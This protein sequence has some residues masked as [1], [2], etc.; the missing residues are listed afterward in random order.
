MNWPDSVIWWHCYPLRFVD[1]ERE[2]I[3][4][5]EPRLWRLTNWLDYV[6]ELGANGLLLAPVFASRTHGY[7]TIDHYRIDPR[8][9][10]DADF[11]DLIWKAKE[12][13]VRV[14]LDG[15]FNHVS[16]HHEIVR[17][18]LADG[19]GSEA[20][21]WI[22]W[23]DGYPRGFEGNLDLVE[24]D[25]SHPPVQDYVVG[26]M[27]HWLDRGA[28]GWRLDAAYAAGPEAW[29]P[30][31]DRVRQAHPDAWI[32]AEVIHGDYVDFVDRSGVDSVT[33]YELWKAIWSSLNDGNLHELAWTLSRH[34]QFAS[35]FRPLN[36]VGNHDTTRIA[37]QLTDGRHLALADAL[38]LLLPG[39]PAIYAGD[40][41]GFTA[42]KTDGPAGDDAVRPPFPVD[43]GGLAPFGRPT[44]ELHQ[45]LIHLRRS[46]PWLAWAGLSVGAVTN[47]TIAINLDGGH[48]R[49]TLALNVGDEPVELPGLNGPLPVA[50][51]DWALA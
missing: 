14:L 1:A 27:T 37:T 10:A 18:A 51:H 42:E 31:V 46:H 4:N 20:G 41:Q 3:D 33:E 19:P 30:I 35:R 34:A 50:A 22:R 23:V 32:L 24:L 9:G 5:V 25:L 47:E 17:R 2:A 12:R 11:D 16:D 45:R 15:V 29:R 48:E 39:V 49:L 6:L 44:F 40:E 28:D 7:D 21:R 26:V 13:G 8:L 43:P 38:L 36:F